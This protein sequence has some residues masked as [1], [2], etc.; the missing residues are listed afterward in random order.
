MHAVPQIFLFKDTSEA[1]AQEKWRNFKLICRL[2][3]KITLR[4]PV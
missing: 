4:W 1:Y 2:L 3:D